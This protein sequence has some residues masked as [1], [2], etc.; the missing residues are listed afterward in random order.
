[1]DVNRQL[2]PSHLTSHMMLSKDP[3]GGGL[4]QREEGNVTDVCTKSRAF[5][6]NSIKKLIN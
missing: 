4:E 1:M 3:A 6:N 2:L 5:Y